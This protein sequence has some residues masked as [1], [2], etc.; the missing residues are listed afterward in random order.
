MATQVFSCGYA[1][2]NR[3]FMPNY[4][5]ANPLPFFVHVCPG[6]MFAAYSGEFEATDEKTKKKEPEIPAW[7]KY[8]LLAQRLI[9]EQLDSVESLSGIAWAYLQSAWAAR[10]VDRNKE[11][12]RMRLEDALVFFKRVYEKN[13]DARVTYTCGEINRLLGNFDEAI[14]FF[15]EVPDHAEKTHLTEGEENLDWLIEM[16]KE[17]K[18]AAKE[19]KTEVLKM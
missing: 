9:D 5:G 19:G 8:Y 16:S 1:S 2:K 11:K 14:G 18:T 4:W 6:C 12:E 3:D 13:T 15:D 7:E 17:Q 10:V